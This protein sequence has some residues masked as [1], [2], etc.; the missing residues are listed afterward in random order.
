MLQKFKSGDLVQKTFRKVLAFGFDVFSS[1]ISAYVAVLW[2]VTV[3]IQENT[4]KVTYALTA[5]THEVTNSFYV[6]IIQVFYSG[7]TS[8]ARHIH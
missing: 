3:A 8:L 7:S 6:K 2:V 1:N 4:A 5:T